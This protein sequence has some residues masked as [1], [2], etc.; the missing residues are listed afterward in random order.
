MNIFFGGTFIKKEK[1]E[2]AGVKHPIKL[3]YYKIINEDEFINKDKAKYGIKVVKTE[4]MDNDVKT[5]NKEIRHLSNNEQQKNE[6]LGLLKRNE[7]TPICV[8]DIIS[9]FQY[10]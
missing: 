4:Y 9:D 1:L 10:L 6:M 2:E 5:E 8:Q 3:E 7:V